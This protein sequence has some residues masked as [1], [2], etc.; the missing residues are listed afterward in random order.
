MGTRRPS[1]R[2]TLK[3]GWGQTARQA[4]SPS[5]NTSIG[6]RKAQ[7]QACTQNGW[8]LGSAASGFP[9]PQHLRESL[10]V[11]VPGLHSNYIGFRHCSM[12]IL[13][14]AG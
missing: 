1:A 3:M 13:V 10:R 5:L 11:P 6:T 7:C 14:G 12:Q 2:P 9:L 8:G 4:D